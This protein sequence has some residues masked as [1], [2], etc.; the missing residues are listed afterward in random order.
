MLLLQVCPY[1]LTLNKIS[2]IWAFF[3]LL[4]FVRIEEGNKCGGYLVSLCWEQS[5][6][7]TLAFCSA[8]INEPF[9]ITNRKKHLQTAPV[10]KLTMSTSDI[11]CFSIHRGNH[12]RRYP[13]VH[14]KKHH[15]S[16]QLIDDFISCH[17]EWSYLQPT[18]VVFN[19]FLLIF[20]VFFVIPQR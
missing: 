4:P 7:M 5:G 15:S 10:I 18:H 2:V 16:R 11:L 1:F 12:R 6:L 9:T 8:W 20:Q 14:K 19:C 13:A 17:P 3:L